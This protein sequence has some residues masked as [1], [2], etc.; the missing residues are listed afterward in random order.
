MV[1]VVNVTRGAGGD[2]D[3]FVDDD[4]NGYVIYSAFY[5]MSIELL[6][7]D[8]LY[9]TGITAVAAAN[10]RC[11]SVRGGRCWSLS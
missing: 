8:F 5:G 3:L 11:V 4:G 10:G 2:Y 6:T 7:R 1:D 9:S